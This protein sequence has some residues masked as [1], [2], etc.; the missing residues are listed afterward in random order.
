MDGRFPAEDARPPGPGP[1]HL[2]LS[3]GSNMNVM[4]N[5]MSQDLDTTVQGVQTAITLFFLSWPP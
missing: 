1:V 5:D 3:P 2:Q 4:I